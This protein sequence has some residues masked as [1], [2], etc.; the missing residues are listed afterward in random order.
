MLPLLFPAVAARIDVHGSQ[1]ECAPTIGHDPHRLLEGTDMTVPAVVLVLL[2][3]KKPACRRET[4]LKD[5]FELSDDLCVGGSALSLYARVSRPEE[6][7]AW[8]TA[9]NRRGCRP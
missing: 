9:L 4:P 2:V 8:P 1:Y 5:V 6:R 7:M 3:V